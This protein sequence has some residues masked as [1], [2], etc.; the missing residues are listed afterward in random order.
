MLNPFEKEMRASASNVLK[1]IAKGTP[2]MAMSFIPEL[3]KVILEHNVEDN[4]EY[5][6]K[7]NLEITLYVVNKLVK[8]NVN[9]VVVE[10]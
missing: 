1:L 3:I 5:K 8:S 4:V 7:E 6:E 2:T 10:Q 9:A